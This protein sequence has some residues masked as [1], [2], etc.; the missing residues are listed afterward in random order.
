MT[1]PP[2]RA[3]RQ[4]Q[5]QNCVMHRVTAAP[6][7]A[8]RP[9]ISARSFRL[10]WVRFTVGPSNACRPS[11]EAHDRHGRQSQG[12]PVQGG[13]RHELGKSHCAS[14]PSANRSVHPNSFAISGSMSRRALGPIGAVALMLCGAGAA[15]PGIGA[16]AGY[17]PLYPIG[18]KAVGDRLRGAGP[19]SGWEPSLPFLPKAVGS[20]LREA[21]FPR[22]LRRLGTLSGKKS[23]VGK[24]SRYHRRSLARP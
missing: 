19:S 16:A 3:R 20:R 18:Y 5:W 2:Y 22:A 24:V 14:P 9:A 1:P 11:R 12:Q 21:R 10:S 8:S 4:S 6:Y 23:V 7:R 15:A 13:Q 17:P